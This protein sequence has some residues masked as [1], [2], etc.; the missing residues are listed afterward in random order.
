MRDHVALMRAVTPLVKAIIALAQAVIALIRERAAPAR[1]IVAFVG[2]R[3]ALGSPIA[4]RSSVP[5]PLA[6]QMG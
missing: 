5:A 2:A 1:A 3:S 6:P 4:H